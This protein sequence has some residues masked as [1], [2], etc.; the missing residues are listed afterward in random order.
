MGTRFADAA[1]RLENPVEA[2]YNGYYSSPNQPCQSPI[3][4]TARWGIAWKSAIA[5]QANVGVHAGD[6]AQPGR[7]SGRF[8]AGFQKESE[9][10]S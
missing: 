8:L 9:R 7:L 3:E 2:K 6:N 1:S 10:V 5:W 4:G